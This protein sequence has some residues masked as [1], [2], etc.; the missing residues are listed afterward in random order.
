MT[1]SSRMEG[2]DYAGVQYEEE[3]VERD[4]SEEVFRKPTHDLSS[5]KY[6]RRSGSDSPPSVPL[7]P[8]LGPGEGARRR[9][10]ERSNQKGVTETEKQEKSS[11]F[12]T[13][14]QRVD[15]IP[16]EH[17]KIRSA[18]R[19]RHIR[20]GEGYLE[21]GFE[22]SS[23]KDRG[24]QEF[25]GREG[26]TQLSSRSEVYSRDRR[27]NRDRGREHREVHQAYHDN[28]AGRRSCHH[29]DRGS[30]SSRPTHDRHQSRESSGQERRTREDRGRDLGDYR[31][32]NTDQSRQHERDKSGNYSRGRDREHAEVRLKDRRSTGERDDRSRPE[33]RACDK[34]SDL[35]S[36][37]KQDVKG[38][39]IPQL[40]DKHTLEEIA[41]TVAEEGQLE[42]PQGVKRH[43][44]NHTEDEEE[45]T[46]M[47]GASSGV[48][49]ADLAVVS[50]D[51][52]FEV[53]ACSAEAA[54]EK[55]PV[56]VVEK[57]EKSAKSSKW[58]PPADQVAPVS[59]AQALLPLPLSL[60]LP[61]PMP[62]PAPVPVPLLPPQE[63]ALLAARKAAEL[64]NRN[65][66]VAGCMTAEEK[67]KMLWGSKKAAVE[68]EPAAAVGVNRWDT[69]HFS[70]R[71]REEKFQKLMGV[72][73]ILESSP[74]VDAKC[75]GA[76]ELFTE[77]KQRRLQ[78]DLEKQ[79][80]VGLKRRDG[81][82][83]GLGL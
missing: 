66:G 69:V 63:A 77:D 14:R 35:E 18:E 73:S 30:L 33:K 2:D 21:R 7:P 74:E 37:R 16:E 38:R 34:G 43:K 26:A 72:K 23:G 46:K 41:K 49:P 71:G 67:K 52:P 75:G 76:P 45:E 56:T 82:T 59:Q 57:R 79:F 44:M 51:R 78:D 32:S 65:L 47:S 28:G 24:R 42:S 62:L 29:S 11:N 64:V 60:P 27:D 61:Q 10:Q 31:A 20:Q 22:R 13:K 17:D 70:D 80:E 48:E 83:V 36:C 50:V 8:H 81:R 3:L 53:S 5:R 9:C 1:L 15:A 40:D 12:E 68:Q 19:K 4:A 39:D 55:A 58:G 6:R 54:A 25:G